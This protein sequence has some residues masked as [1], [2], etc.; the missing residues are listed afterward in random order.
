MMQIY[1]FVLFEHYTLRFNINCPLTGYSFFVLA[2]DKGSHLLVSSFLTLCIQNK[3]TT[4]TTTKPSKYPPDLAHRILTV[5][6]H[7]LTCGF[8]NCTN[9]V[10]F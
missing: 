5:S 6:L 7:D 2:A 4:T 10:I 9:F 1:S 8:C 3:Q